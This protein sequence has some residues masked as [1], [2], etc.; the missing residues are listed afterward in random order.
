MQTPPRVRGLQDIRHNT[1][2]SRLG[3][4]NNLAQL[5]RE[6]ERITQE[7]DNWQKKL[8]LIEARLGQIAETE[9]NLQQGLAA[10]DS[11]SAARDEPQ[12]TSRQVTVHQKRVN[13]VSVNTVTLRY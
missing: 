3:M 2:Q 13:E 9:N 5:Q 7:K 12:E 11:A 1:R 4:L 10:E 8:A 6:K